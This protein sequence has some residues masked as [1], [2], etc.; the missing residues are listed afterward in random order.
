MAYAHRHGM[1]VA[2]I[3]HD[4]IPIQHPEF[5]RPGLTALHRGYMRE[6]SKIDLLLPTS[7]TSASAWRDVIKGERLA[8]PTLKI[9]PLAGEIA[10]VPRVLDPPV[11]RTGTIRA[12][13]V[14]TV[15]P[16]KNHRT[17]CAALE[18]IAA[19]AGGL[20]FQM[21]LVGAPDLAAPDL[22]AFL[23][24]AERRFAGQLRWHRRVDS[25]TLRQLYEQCDFTV[26]PSV[27]EGFGLPIIESLWFA[28]PCICANFGVMQENAHAGGCLTVDVRDAT[29]LA[30]A[31]HRLVAEPDLRNRLALEATLRPIRTWSQYADEIVQAL[32]RH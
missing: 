15:E 19:T 4:A 21:D 29:A 16:R 6:L 13:C 5:A 18:Q 26:Y 9:V 8:S 17:L 32:D 12:L 31:M 30:A 23:A 11:P 20:P 27:V 22:E 1:R 10:G 14:S 7:E 24:A 2:A 3:F 28:R 25:G